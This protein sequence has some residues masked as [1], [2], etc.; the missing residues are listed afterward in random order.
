MI[1]DF[2][3]IFF[4]IFWNFLDFCIF[5]KIFQSDPKM[6][7]DLSEISHRWPLIFLKRPKITKFLHDFV[8]F[9]TVFPKI[10]KSYVILRFWPRIWSQRSDLPLIYDTIWPILTGN[11]SGL[12]WEKSIPQNDPGTSNEATYSLIGARGGSTMTATDNELQYL[13]SFLILAFFP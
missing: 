2:L 7:S 6:T 11:R 9:D 3:M 4:R 12:V 1:F 8:D 13:T 10:Q 5:L